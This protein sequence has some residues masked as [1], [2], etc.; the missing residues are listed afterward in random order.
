M[1]RKGL[2]WI[3]ATT[4]VASMSISMLTG[5]QSKEEETDVTATEQSVTETQEQAASTHVVTFYDA[6]G[7]T[8]QKRLKMELV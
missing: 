3:A 2:K 6:D 4:L 1:K 8:R 5:C 7:K